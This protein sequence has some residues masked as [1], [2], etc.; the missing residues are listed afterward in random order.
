MKSTKHFIDLILNVDDH[1]TF[2]LARRTIYD[3][4]SPY[5]ELTYDDSSYKDNE[6]DPQTYE[7]IAFDNTFIEED[8]MYYVTAITRPENRKAGY[9]QYIVLHHIT[10]LV[11]TPYIQETVIYKDHEK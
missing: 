11:S 6:N 2:T 5:F 4:L 7:M 9:E 10:L 8:D 1:K 3:S